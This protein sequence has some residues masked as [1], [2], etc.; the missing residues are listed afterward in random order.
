M[1][2]FVTK[3]EYPRQRTTGRRGKIIKRDEGNP[4][5]IAITTLSTHAESKVQL[6]KFPKLKNFPTLELKNC[7]SFEGKIN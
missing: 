3:E 6:D 2:S 7:K 5:R 4:L 1:D